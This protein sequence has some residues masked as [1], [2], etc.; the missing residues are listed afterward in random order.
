MMTE[1][2]MEHRKLELLERAKDLRERLNAINNDFAQGLDSDWE[3]QA[4]QLENDEVL[5]EIS[6]VTAEE[7]LKVEQGIERLA[8]AIEK[9]HHKH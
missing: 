1:A 2:E 3:E 6:R 8:Q 7:L 4:T 9:S 5:Q